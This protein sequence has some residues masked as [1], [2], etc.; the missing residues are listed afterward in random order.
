MNFA[1]VDIESVVPHRGRMLMVD[2]LLASDPDSVVVS[3]EIRADNLFADAH[4]VPTWVGIEYMAQAIAAWAGCRALAR[5]E[6]AKIG[7]LLGTRRYDTCC[8]HFS[9]GMQLRIEA[10]R[11]LFGENGL[12]MFSCRILDGE[13]ELASAH[14]S[15]FEPPDA[16]AFLEN[17]YA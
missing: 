2:Q 4:G 11:E 17:Q 12:G 16:A 5:N 7:F 13:S 8:Q 15:V 9:F 3:A 1:G 6:P 14:V 10:T